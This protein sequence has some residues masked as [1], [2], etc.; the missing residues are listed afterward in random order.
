VFRATMPREVERTLA[1]SQEEPRH[2]PAVRQRARRV[3]RGL[4]RPFQQL[5]EP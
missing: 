2:R 3:P 1:E 4:A 5:D